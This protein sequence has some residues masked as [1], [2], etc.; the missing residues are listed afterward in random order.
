MNT[1]SIKNSNSSTL[2]YKF[3]SI[4]FISNSYR[5]IVL[6]NIRLNY[7]NSSS[8]ISITVELLN[9]SIRC[10]LK[11]YQSQELLIVVLEV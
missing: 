4:L 9:I 11:L 6:I 7:S 3:S 10:S 8:S 1:K 2:A 5:G